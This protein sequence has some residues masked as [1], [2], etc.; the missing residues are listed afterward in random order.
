MVLGLASSCCQNIFVKIMYVAMVQFCLSPC[1]ASRDPLTPSCLVVRLL[2]QQV[3][4][5]IRLTKR[6]A[7]LVCQMQT[8]S[9]VTPSP[10]RIPP[11]GPVWSLQEEPRGLWGRTILLAVS[12]PWLW[13]CT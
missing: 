3:S 1:A 2:T 9:R 7:L 6:S 10:A 12:A 8:A 5:A 13:C 11:Q 4:A